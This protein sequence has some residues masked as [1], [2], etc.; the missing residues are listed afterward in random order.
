MPS[1]QWEAKQKQDPKEER[2]EEMAFQNAKREMKTIHSHSNS[3][4]SENECC[5]VLHVM[6]GGSWDITSWCIIK[7]VCWEVVA[8]IPAPKVAPHCKGMETSISFDTSDCPKSMAGARQ[9]WLIVSP[10]IANIKL[11]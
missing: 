4:S 10:T 5:L 11:Y 6:F 1:R 2:D 3:E 9:L 8:A 7:T